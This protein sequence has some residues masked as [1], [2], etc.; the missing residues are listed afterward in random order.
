MEVNGQLHDSAVLGPG[1]AQNYGRL[2]DR[3]GKLADRDMLETGNFLFV[4]GVE[5]RFDG[6]ESSTVQSLHHLRHL[7]LLSCKQRGDVRM[8]VILRSVRVENVTAERQKVFDIPSV[9]L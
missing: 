1:K 9:C 2:A 3:E 7:D 6:M 8:N 5:P 4:T